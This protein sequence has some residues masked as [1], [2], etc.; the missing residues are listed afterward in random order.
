MAV[1]ASLIPELERAVA[2][3][4]A[5][6]RAATLRRITTLFLDGAT[7]FTDEHVKLFDD[8][9]GYLIEEIETQALAE[10]ARRIAP[11]PNAPPDVVR[12][13]AQ[14]RATLDASASPAVCFTALRR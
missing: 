3:G 10:L 12:T 1:A 2:Q 4:T 6:K 5:E 9:M 14:P 11:I 13:L 8:V 7:Q